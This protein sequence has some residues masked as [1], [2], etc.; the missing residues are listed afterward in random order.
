MKIFR[1]SQNQRPGSWYLILVEVIRT[2][3]QGPGT[4]TRKE[5]PRKKP[6]SF[7]LALAAGFS[8]VPAGHYAASA[9]DDCVAK[10]IVSGYANGTFKPD[11]PVTRAQFCVMLARALYPQETAAPEPEAPVKQPAPETLVSNSTKKAGSPMFLLSPHGPP[12][13]MRSK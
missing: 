5:Y 2:N 8:D 3:F 12:M 13:T 6:F 10:G 4:P 7:L 9:I 1:E 11:E